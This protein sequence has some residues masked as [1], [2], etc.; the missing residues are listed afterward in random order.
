MPSDLR[1]LTGFGP[2]INIARDPRFGRTS[3]LAGEDPLL[4]D[5]VMTDIFLQLNRGRLPS[6]AQ[7]HT[8]NIDARCL[9]IGNARIDGAASIS[10]AYVSS[11]AGAIAR[12]I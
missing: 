9:A 1:C 6:S 5:L 3:E 7:Q 2:N 11:F 4:S 8:S 12:K 10:F